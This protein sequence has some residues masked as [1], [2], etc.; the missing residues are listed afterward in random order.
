M[1]MSTCRVLGVTTRYRESQVLLAVYSHRHLPQGVWTCTHLSIDHRHVSFFRVFNFRGWPRLRNYFNTEIFPIYGTCSY[2]MY[3]CMY[4]VI[5]SLIPRPYW[6]LGMRLS[7]LLFCY[8]II[9]MGAL[10]R[11]LGT[12]G[13]ICNS[14]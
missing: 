9:W 5:S 8:T 12:F 13:V 10:T 11:T 4:Q 6:S 7:S 2:T 1:W 14:F 3:T